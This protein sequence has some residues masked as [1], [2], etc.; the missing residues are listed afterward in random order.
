[1]MELWRL[2]IADGNT[3]LARVNRAEVEHYA[4]QPSPFA[5]ELAGYGSVNIAVDPPDAQS[6]LFE[7]L[8]LR[9][10]DKDGN[11]LP[12]RTIPVPYDAKRREVDQ[13]FIDAER[14]LLFGK[15]S[16]L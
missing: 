6:Y 13:A 3:E 8:P 10:T 12:S 1:Y 15:S 11:A 9:A 2:A 16:A 5:T 7:F 4:P 14:V